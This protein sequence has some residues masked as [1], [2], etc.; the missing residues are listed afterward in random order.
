MHDDEIEIGD[1]LVRR[2]VERDL[3]KLAG[4]PLRRL[5]ESGSSNVLFRLGSEYLVRLPR[6]PG[7]STSIEREARWLPRLARALPVDVPQVITVG[8]PGFGY[9][10]RWALTRW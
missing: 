5:P 3:P 10:E 1:E 2:L 7:G 9:P 8:E 4:L 6:Q